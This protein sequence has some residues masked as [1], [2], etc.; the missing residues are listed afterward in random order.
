MPVSSL[1]PAPSF[2][3]RLLEPPGASSAHGPTPGPPD[4][5][6][7]VGFQVSEVEGRIAED[8]PVPSTASPSTVLW[9]PVSRHTQP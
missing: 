3:T 7:G 5:P 2:L 9:G 1:S 4:S 8:R 6:R